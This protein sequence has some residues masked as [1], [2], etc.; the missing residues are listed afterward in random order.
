[1]SYT[2]SYSVT[3][4]EEMS[5]FPID[6][7]DKVDDFLDIYEKVGL[8]DFSAY[9]GKIT[10]SW[11]GLPQS[12]PRYSYAFNN[13]LWHY[14]VGL[15]NYQRSRFGEYYT[16][17]KVLHFEWPSR[18]SHICLVELYD[19]YTWDGVFWLPPV[20]ALLQEPAAPANDTDSELIA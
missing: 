3:F 12:D 14:H 18:G 19:H 10:P 20:E 16:S 17:D 8:A 11:K 15:P 7:L 6:Q 4:A 13:E 2:F 1:M 5:R 9:P